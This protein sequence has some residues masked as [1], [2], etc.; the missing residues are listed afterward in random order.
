M[1]LVNV[2][3]WEVNANELVHK[4][5]IEDLTLGS[6]L[7]VYPGQTALFVKGGQIFDEF[8]SGTHTIKSENL[9]LLNKVF[10]LPFGGESPFQAE[11]WFVNLVSLL[12]CK[13]GAAS[14]IQVEDPQY[15]VIVPLRSYGQYGF[16]ISKPQLFLEKL[17][18][19][20]ST[21]ETNQVK[22]YFRG[23]IL[24]KLTALISQKVYADNLSVININSHIED[25]ARYAKSKLVDVFAEY[26]ISL[27]MFSVMAITVNESD[28]SF[29]KL[30]KTKDDLA[31]I[32]IMGHDNYKLD[33]SFDVLETAAGNTSSGMAGTAAG[34]GAGVSIGSAI[35][36]LAKQQ[37]SK[38]SV[39]TPPPLPNATKYF[40]GING[41][42]QG[43]F[44]LQTIKDS[45][46]SNKID[47]DTLVWKR[48]MTD[49]ARL[50]DS[51]DFASLFSNCPPPLPK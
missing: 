40:L 3:Q 31:R 45:I 50:A 14:P 37:L 46:L 47:G 49:W 29:V 25:I 28:E 9:P 10:N 21:F 26:G 5:P 20:M 22:S 44:D 48:G 13:W 7:V 17:S 4:F 39:G 43:P 30:K 41:L 35:G 51:A 12:D 11:V 2:I 16:K 23:V 6:Q 27:E 32:E 18:G 42:Q 38:D 34:I 33:R 1:A 8:K 19:N 36:D 24:S 15:K